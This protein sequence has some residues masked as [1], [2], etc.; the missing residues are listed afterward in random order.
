MKFEVGDNSGRNIT[1]VENKFYC[2][3]FHYFYLRPGRLNQSRSHCS[4]NR[5]RNLDIY[6]R[7]AGAWRRTRLQ[8]TAHFQS[9]SCPD[10][11][12][13]SVWTLRRAG[14]A[15]AQINPPQ[16]PS[17]RWEG[18]GSY[19]CR[20]DLSD[21]SPYRFEESMWAPSS[22]F[23]IK[24]H[25]NANEF[26]CIKQYL[27][28]R[29]RNIKATS[30]TKNNVISNVMNMVSHSVCYAES[31]NKPVPWISLWVFKVNSLFSPGTKASFC[32]I[33]ALFFT[34]EWAIRL[35]CTWK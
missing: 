31:I 7:Q 21:K 17:G 5:L 12:Y 33:K 25:Q 27:I 14:L 30:A 19:Q 22:I 20:G 16:I 4:E 28:L 15:A 9:R 35:C 2:G 3:T 32:R 13:T 6:G 8:P 18:G 26:C 1:V 11:N 34:T 24:I 23:A 10:S 29:W